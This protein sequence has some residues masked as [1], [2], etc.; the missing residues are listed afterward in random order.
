[1]RFGHYTVFDTPEENKHTQV[2]V[3]YDVPNN[4][5][6]DGASG[7]IVLTPG[8]EGSGIDENRPGLLS[9][10]ITPNISSTP[11]YATAFPIYY[12][13][14]PEGETEVVLNFEV[15]QGVINDQ[16]EFTVT[17]TPSSTWYVFKEDDGEGGVVYGEQ[18]EA[19]S[20][21]CIADAGGL[22]FVTIVSNTNDTTV[23]EDEVQ[24]MVVAC[25]FEAEE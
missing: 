19:V 2:Y 1:M 10:R 24:S 25:I 9:I 22:E 7:S 18:G 13:E 5:N 23:P 14:L 4:D 17:A 11:A 8:G 21:E 3:E 6:L 12:D 20:Y 16:D 15:G